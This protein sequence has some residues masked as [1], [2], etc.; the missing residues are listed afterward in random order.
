MLMWFGRMCTGDWQWGEFPETLL[1]DDFSEVL[2]RRIT[3]L[4]AMQQRVLEYA[5]VFLG[6]FSFELLAEIWRGDELELLDVLDDLV[7]EGLLTTYGDEKERYQFSQSLC[8]RAIYDR[9]QNVRRRL[10]HREIGNALEDTEDAEELT[11][12][13]AD[14]FAAAE[15]QDKAV[16]YMRLSGKKALAIQAYRQGLRRFEAVRDWTTN[17]AFESQADAID[18][19]CDYA[20][21][22]RNCDQHNRAL[23]LLE[24]AKALLPDDRNDLKARILN[25]EGSIHSVLQHGAIAEEYMLEALRLYR[26][27]DDLDGEI[28]ALGGLAYLCDVSGRHEEAIA[29]MRREIEKYATLGEAQNKAVLQRREGLFALVGFRFKTAK[30]HLEATVKTAQQLGLEYHQIWALNLLVRVYFYLGDL[31][32]AEAVCYEVIGE[33]QKRGVI[34]L[35]AVNF[36]YLG[37]WHWNAA[38]L[39]RH[40]NMPRSQQS[41]FWKHR[42]KIMSIALMRFQQRLLREWEMWNQQWNGQKEPAKVR[43]KYRVC[44][45]VYCLWC[46]VVLALLWLRQ[47]G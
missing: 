37:N 4:P 19:L 35:E 38:I 45:R 26:E 46:I 15:E 36:L 7:A 44:T 6:D 2:Y 39:L 40:W 9:I 43:N 14:H 31:N 17:D 34:H 20:D 29:Y 47:G 32:R 16:K 13:L 30:S 11:E 1:S 25:R 24:E 33:W 5:C 23:K 28:Q 10:L 12:E 42:E 18:F 27:L 41:D 22:L 21:V 3:A 8:R